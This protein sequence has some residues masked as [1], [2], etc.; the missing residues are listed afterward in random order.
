MSWLG[1]IERIFKYQCLHCEEPHEFQ[2][3]SKEQNDF[4]PPSCDKCASDTLTYVSFRNPGPIFNQT[5]V[6]V[7]Y[8][9]N[10]RKARKI[11]NQYISETKLNY[12]E[13]GK[14]ENKY[15]KSYEQK[16]SADKEKNEVYLKTETNKRKAKVKTVRSGSI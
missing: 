8:D 14:I 1:E 13:T 16:L 6:S 15:T 4:K 9:Q 3:A 10:G 11:G 12:L 2:M 5:V 7:S